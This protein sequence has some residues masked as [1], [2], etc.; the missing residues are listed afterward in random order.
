[1]ID[2]RIADV[3]NVNEFSNYIVG[4]DYR[5]EDYDDC[6][7]YKTLM[8]KVGNKI[9]EL[10]SNEDY[11][12]SDDWIMFSGDYITLYRA[13]PTDGRGNLIETIE[14]GNIGMS[15]VSNINDLE[16]VPWYNEDS[17]VAKVVVPTN[18]K[19]YIAFVN[20]YECM[21]EVVLPN[22]CTKYKVEIMESKDA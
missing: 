5:N 10:W 20:Y 2:M 11:D 19:S 16:K 7:G 15:W 14:Q 9:T 22:V 21:V 3:H 8:T 18:D 13:L 1:M 4:G 17:V 12:D 6:G